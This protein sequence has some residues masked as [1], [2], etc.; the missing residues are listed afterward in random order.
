[1]LMASLGVYAVS[2]LL[3]VIFCFKTDKDALWLAAVPLFL[4][5]YE[6]FPDV[7]ISSFA[8]IFISMVALFIF[9]ARGDIVHGIAMVFV[10]IAGVLSTL[11]NGIWIFLAAIF[12]VFLIANKYM[13]DDIKKQLL[14]GGIS[15]L[16]AEYRQPDV[17]SGKGDDIPQQMPADAYESSGIPEQQ[18]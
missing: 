8:A 3:L 16:D 7:T 15:P 18:F 11:F 12:M 13:P 9:C 2:L 5:G 4:F 10:T 14:G 1:M 17:S 6:L